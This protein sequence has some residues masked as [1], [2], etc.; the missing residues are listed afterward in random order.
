MRSVMLL[1][2]KNMGYDIN[3]DNID[4]LNSQGKV[5]QTTPLVNK[6]RNEAT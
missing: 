6:D 1:I 2:K 4:Q 3:R 5:K